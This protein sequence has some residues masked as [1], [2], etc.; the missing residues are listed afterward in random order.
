MSSAGSVLGRFLCGSPKET[1]VCL[2]MPLSV[3]T[4]RVPPLG[5][6]FQWAEAF[7]VIRV[8]QRSV[9]GETRINQYFVSLAVMP[10]RYRKDASVCCLHPC[11]RVLPT[12]S[13]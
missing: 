13:A 2:S 9:R 12:Q 10:L 3:V 5:A 7:R 1:F 11:F 6:P 8:I 4:A